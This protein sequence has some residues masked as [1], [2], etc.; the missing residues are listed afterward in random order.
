MGLRRVFGSFEKTVLVLVVFLVVIYLVI[1]FGEWRNDFTT[2]F[3]RTNNWGMLIF[4]M[5]LGFL[6]SG[7]LVKL[8]QWEIRVQ[9]KRR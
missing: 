4:I 1:S 6:I 3:L 9:R 7:I 5:L 2:W 8:V